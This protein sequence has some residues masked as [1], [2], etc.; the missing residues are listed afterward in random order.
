GALCVVAPVPH[1][2][3]RAA[4]PLIARR[5][6]F[7]AAESRFVQRSFGEAHRRASALDSRREAA[8]AL[9]VLLVA[10]CLIVAGSV[11]AVQAATDLADAWSVPDALVGD[12]KSVV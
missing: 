10:L 5:L 3:P 1:V 4:G 6:P 7:N 9:L 8:G 11:G 12:R 2:A